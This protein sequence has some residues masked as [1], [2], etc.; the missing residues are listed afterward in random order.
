MH[1]E[2][3][4]LSDQEWQNLRTLTF[5]SVDAKADGDALR[6]L[7]LTGLP[8]IRAPARLF[9][10][11]IDFSAPAARQTEADSDEEAF[12]ELERLD[13]DG[14]LVLFGAQSNTWS[15]NRDQKREQRKDRQLLYD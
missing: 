9:A 12:A 3:A 10:G 2:G 8:V 1:E 6:T 4:D 7:H 13:L 14:A 11:A 15:T 5:G